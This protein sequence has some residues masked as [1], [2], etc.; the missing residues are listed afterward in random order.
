MTT[1]FND[2]P[3]EKFDNF[4]EKITKNVKN[5]KINYIDIQDFKN[6]ESIS[7]QLG[8]WNIIGG[9]NANGKSSLVEAI[10]TAIQSNKF[11]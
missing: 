2:I 6:I 8:D 3:Q 9:Y 11:Y 4:A 7:T 10:L 1:N 5:L